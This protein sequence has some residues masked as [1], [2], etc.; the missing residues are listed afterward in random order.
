MY[1]YDEWGNSMLHIQTGRE[2][3]KMFKEMGYKNP[4]KKEYEKHMTSYRKIQ[5][6]KNKVFQEWLDKFLEYCKS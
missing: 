1:T 5:E 3:M 4:P 6:E 2:G